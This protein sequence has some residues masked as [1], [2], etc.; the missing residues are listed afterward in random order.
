M[1]AIHADT[2]ISFIFC[3]VI[4]CS[5]ILLTV[6]NLML[7]LYRIELKLIRMLRRCIIKVY[8]LKY[9]KTL[10]MIIADIIKN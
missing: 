8:V 4:N 5:I 6:F 10:H 1:L 7:C 3:H 9:L 2:G